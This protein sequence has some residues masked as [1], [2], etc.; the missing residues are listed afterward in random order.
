MVRK[1]IKRCAI[2]LAAW[3]PFFAIWLLV[4]MSFARDRFS[5]VLIESLISMGSAGLLGI[6]VWYVCQR[7]PWPLGFKL[8]FYLLQLFF[9]MVYGIAWTA[10]IYGLESL[11]VR[12]AL[13][14][15]WSWAVL[16]RQTLMGVWFYAVFAG[17]SH[18]VQTR[19][20]LHEKET[21]AAR[22]EAL[23]A[24]ARLDAIR[25]RLNPHFLFNA[26]HTLAALVKFRPN[27]AEGAIERLG[28]MLRYT[29][30]EDGRELV[31]FSEEYDFT[32]QYLAF[33]Q[34]RY[35]DR[36]KV[37]LQIDPESFNFDLPPFSIQTLA[38]NA[39]QHAIAI[40]PKAGR[41]GSNAPVVTDG[42]KSPFEMTDLATARIPEPPTNSVCARCASVSRQ[43]TDPQPSCA[44]MGAW[45]ASKRAL[46]FPLVGN[47]LRRRDS[48][49]PRRKN[50]HCAREQEAA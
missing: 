12:N 28:D 6:A 13:Q 44:S 11:R 26:L 43:H 49:G 41:Y 15:S 27:M 25:A 40:R 39:V 9:A 2:A 10:S 19:N 29:L 46:S 3:L 35:E 7:C 36:L 45:A 8:N 42:F 17:I 34:L 22:A 20:R 33:E 50:R 32:R 24:A 38:E 48:R 47:R 21:I 18:A 37:D 5:A 31:E 1:R 16:G 23:A 4:A 30:K 14:S